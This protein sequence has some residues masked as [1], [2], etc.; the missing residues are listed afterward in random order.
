[1]ATNARVEETDSLTSL[2]ERIHRAVQLVSQLRQEKESVQK[3]F[4]AVLAEKEAAIHAAT[5]LQAQLNTVSEEL[6]SLKSER[7]QVRTRIEKLLGQMDLLS[8]T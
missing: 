6:D 4:E 3:Q 7:K 5:D 8:A 2:E 1:M